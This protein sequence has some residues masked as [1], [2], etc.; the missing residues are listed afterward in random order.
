[1]LNHV[2]TRG[3]DSVVVNK[4]EL[5]TIIRG[6]ARRHLEVFSES[7]VGYKKQAERLLV[8]ELTKLRDGREFTLNIPLQKPQ[9]HIGDYNKTLK[10]LEMSVDDKIA[11]S[12][13]E[14]SQYVLDDWQW[15][16]G[17]M[18]VASGCGVD[19]NQYYGSMDR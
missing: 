2:S 16:I 8:Q 9:N 18:S 10:M 11:L 5:I 1:M 13:S 7:M 4:C 6:N 17:F 14:F 15:K 3:L 12:S 19:L